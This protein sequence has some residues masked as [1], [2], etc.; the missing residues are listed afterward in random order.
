M[1]NCKGLFTYYV[2]R[3][4]WEGVQQMLT[5]ADKGGRGLSQMLTI[6]DKEGK[7][8]SPKC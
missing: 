1:H 7:G 4:R 8:G 2:S 3:R 6:A 5:I